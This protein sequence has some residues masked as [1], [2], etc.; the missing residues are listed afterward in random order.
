MLGFVIRRAAISILM[1]VAA[2]ALVFAILRLLPG[3]PIITRLGATAGANPE[4]I[5]QL[6]REAGW[7]I[8][9]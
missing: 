3:D 4:A 9:S 5:D 8:R 2:S 1:L 6:R 7:T